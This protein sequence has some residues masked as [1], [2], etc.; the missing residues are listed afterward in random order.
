MSVG[1]KL[2]GPDI[3]TPFVNADLT[4]VPKN[5]TW[6]N[7]LIFSF[8]EVIKGALDNQGPNATHQKNITFIQLPPMTTTVRDT[9]VPSPGLII[10][11]ETTDKAQVYTVGSGWVD[12]H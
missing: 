5:A 2:V 11:N 9:V 4:L 8:N 12:L 3:Y 6:F 1:N 7:L 10:Y